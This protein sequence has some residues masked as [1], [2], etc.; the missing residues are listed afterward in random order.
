MG[1][2]LVVSVFG[3]TDK[4]IIKGWYLGDSHHVEQIWANG[5]VLL[6]TQVQSLVDTMAAFSPPAAGQATLPS[7]CQV[8]L[9]LV[10]A[11]N[12]R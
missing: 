2:N 12:W 1:H 8:A 10:I 6:D 5:R 9:T 11:S 7:S 4:A 3:K